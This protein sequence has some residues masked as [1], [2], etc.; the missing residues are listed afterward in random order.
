MGKPNRNK[1]IVPTYRR[2]SE[3]T[4]RSLTLQ[5]EE[6]YSPIIYFPLSMHPKHL[7]LIRRR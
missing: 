4:N 6:V 7:W 1:K 3:D 2:Q 5:T